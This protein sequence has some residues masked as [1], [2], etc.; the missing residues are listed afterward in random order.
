MVHLWYVCACVHMCECGHECTKTCVWRS[1]DNQVLG[2]H[3]SDDFCSVYQV[4]CPLNFRGSSD[5]TCHLSVGL[6]RKR[7]HATMVSEIQT[8]VLMLVWQVLYS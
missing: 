6:L 5:S 1:E 7:M 2:P 4:S 8:Q 3:F